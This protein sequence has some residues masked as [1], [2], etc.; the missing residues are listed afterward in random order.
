MSRK[1]RTGTEAAEKRIKMKREQFTENW[2]FHMENGVLHDVRL[3]HDA[4]QEA[5]RE[6]G[7]GSGSG[8]A[9]Y[10]GGKYLYEK[11]F[12]M[13]QEWKDREVILELE[14]VYPSAEV[15]LNGKK[16]GT[17]RYGYSGYYVPLCHINAAEENVLAV[18]VDASRQPDSRWYSGSGIYRP[19]W[20]WTENKTHIK[21][22]GIRI[23]TLSTEPAVVSVEVSVE[24]A[25]NRNPGIRSII[26][27][28]GRIV[29]EGKGNKTEISIPDAKLWSAE[30]PDLYECRII[31]E[32]NNE[33]LD[34]QTVSFGIR[35]IS[36]STKGLFIN[37]QNTLLKGGCVHHDNGILGA[38]TFRES[39]FRKVSRLKKAGFNAIRSAH[40]P[41]GKDLLEACDV[42]GMYVM[43]E[44]WDMWYKSKTKYDYAARFES[45]CA[46]DIS[47][48]V[49]KDYNH[50]SVI[51]YSIG[52]EVTEPM[53]EKGIE[54]AKH[55]TEL[56]H[57]QDLSR[58]V[59][60]GINLTL[61]LMASMGIDL[62]KNDGNEDVVP[63]QEM[64]STTYNEMM[65]ESSE[66]MN[67]ASASDEADQISSPV[68]DALDIAGYN[69]ASARYEL[70]SRKHPDRIIVGTETY[71]Y[72]LA[73]N[74][75]MVKKHSY[76]I[77]DFMWTAWDYLGEAGI[78]AW[79]WEEDGASFN[80]KYPWLLADTGAFDIIGNDN[81][82]AG[83]A[84]AVWGAGKKPYIGVVP[85]NHQAD[86]M[87]K[88]MW[89]GTNAIP[90]WSYEGC[91]GRPAHV[92]VYSDGAEAELL[93]N[94]KSAG[95]KKLNGM[96]ADFDTIYE[97]GVLQAVI[98]ND[99]GE[100]ETESE[101][102]SA[103]GEVQIRMEKEPQ[104]I[105]EDNI[106]YVDIDLTGSNGEIEGNAD[107]CLSV[108]VENGELLAYGSANP[109]TE[110]DFLKGRYTT[111]YGRS[112]AVIRTNGQ[113]RVTVKGKNLN[114][115]Q[116]TV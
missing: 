111:W 101:L 112:L 91:E 40:N 14:G 94:H 68:L 69:Y 83:L 6:Q 15:L 7:A 30:H 36:W 38:R 56:F 43:D 8:G 26:L 115:K 72:K 88:A 67:M 78:G 48:M 50:P 21:P 81:A 92:E 60:A 95:R 22:D 70:E 74:W 28:N 90:C 29:A 80:K 54:T 85:V 82:E 10:R 42:L 19:V 113:A 13:P 104:F 108:E 59:T 55:L 45:G 116:M 107:R 12:R 102:R 25:E 24:N 103:G 11:V 34:E 114:E 16:A 79:T 99:A 53:E 31:L 100:K 41:A 49:A 37:G 5:G 63:Q 106:C 51:M 76:I 109:K 35:R 77:G 47:A 23:T 71:A 52:N 17:C 110:E 98:Y 62:T 20:I 97:P 32:E 84:Q 46:E 66:K 87:T 9:Y 3:P 44:G 4:A 93:V 65:S 57:M 61:L 73:E 86:K 58:P 27:Q 39:E 105:P 96:K 64:N 2:T 89:R 1:E 33:V 18:E 75:E